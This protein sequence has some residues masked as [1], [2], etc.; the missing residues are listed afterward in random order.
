MF[1][2]KLLVFLIGGG[3]FLLSVTPFIFN[4]ILP[5]IPGRVNLFWDNWP[6]DFNYYLSIIVQGKNGSFT[7]LDKFTS[8]PHLGKFIRPGY[9][10]LG[11]LARIIGLNETIIYHLARIILGI[12]FI[13]ILF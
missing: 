8:E 13:F 11:H 3:A 4:L 5:V 10:F 2:F 12:I 6:Y 1:N 7:A 9:I